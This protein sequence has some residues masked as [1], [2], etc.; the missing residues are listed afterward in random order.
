ML[1]VGCTGAAQSAAATEDRGGSAEHQS[2]EDAASGVINVIHVFAQAMAWC[3]DSINCHLHKFL[4][5]GIPVKYGP[6]KD[7]M[8]LLQIVPY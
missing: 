2:G 3:M 6:E 4:K 7:I 8:D 5:T 1:L